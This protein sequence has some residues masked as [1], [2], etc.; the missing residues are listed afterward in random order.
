MPLGR[1]GG[2]NSV[3]WWGGRALHHLYPRAF[4]TLP[5]FARTIARKKWGT[6]NCLATSEC[7]WFPISLDL[8]RSWAEFRSFLPPYSLLLALKRF[9][10]Y[11]LHFWSVLSAQPEALGF[12][13]STAS[14]LSPG[15]KT[16]L[17]SSGNNDVIILA[18][19]A[20]LPQGAE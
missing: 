8:L 11:K 3:G 19:P 9:S 1:G 2:V 15:H 14:T 6:V 12:L 17:V 10:S 13:L 16:I 5:S 4:C 18:L 20:I 7:Q